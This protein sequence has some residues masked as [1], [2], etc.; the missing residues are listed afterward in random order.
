VVRMR[1]RKQAM[2]QWIGNSPFERW[3]PA[4]RSLRARLRRR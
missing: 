1:R 4:A 2:L 3:L